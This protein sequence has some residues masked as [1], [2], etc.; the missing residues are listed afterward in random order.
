MADFSMALVIIR[1]SESSGKVEYIPPVGP[2]RDR[3]QSPLNFQG[4]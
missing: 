1:Q 4:S 2:L 3:L